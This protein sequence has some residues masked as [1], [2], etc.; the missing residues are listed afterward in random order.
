MLN[1]NFLIAVAGP[2]K[3]K[4]G[5]KTRR[6]HFRKLIFVEEIMRA[7]LMTEEKPVF[8]LCTEC[9][10]LM[11]KRAKR[12][13]AC[14]RTDHDDRLR[15]VSRQSE[16]LRFLHIRA[17][18]VAGRDTRAEETRTDAK[19]FALLDLITHCVDSERDPPRARLQRR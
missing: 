16:V 2:G 5:Q 18:L 9:A 17:H 15:G 13:N 19:P 14:A 10:P 6:K 3:A 11:Q 8:S 7:P 4:F 12:R 1:V